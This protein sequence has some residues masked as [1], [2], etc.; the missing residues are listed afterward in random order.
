MA[1]MKR[2]V[3]QE[4]HLVYAS[5]DHPDQET[6]VIVRK[7]EHLLLTRMQWYCK[8]TVSR[9]FIK[10]LKHFIVLNEDRAEEVQ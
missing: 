5:P 4:H 3:I 6:T 2:P 1:K 10:A 7:A 9:G 8:K